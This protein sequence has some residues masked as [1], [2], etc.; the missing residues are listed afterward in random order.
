MS[1]KPRP[2]K[3]YH[4]R[5]VSVP[6]YLNSI[7]SQD[8][9]N[10][11][12]DHDRTFLLQVAN[13]TVDE[14]ELALQC[15]LMQAAWLLADNMENTKELRQSIFDGIAAVGAY[16]SDDPLLSKLKCGMETVVLRGRG[17]LW[18]QFGTV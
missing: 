6:P 14:S 16:L 17:L 10:F 13:R 7:Q 12:T 5:A 15:R 4:P 18:A 11:G 3:K 1:K 8:Q 9:S 2:K